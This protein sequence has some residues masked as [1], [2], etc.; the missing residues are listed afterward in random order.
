MTP[1]A[2]AAYR[3]ESGRGRS[4]DKLDEISKALREEAL[5]EMAESFFG[6]RKEVE[7]EKD[8]FLV[9]AGRVRDKGRLALDRAALL[10]ALLLDGAAAPA[11]YAVLGVEPG[12]LL[13]L[14]DPQRARLFL[15]RPIALTRRSRYASYVLDAYSVLHDACDDYLHGSTFEDTE[16]PERKVQT[17]S[18][19]ELRAW[20]D[21]INAEVRRINERMPP[22]LVLECAH[23]LDVEAVAKEEVTGA[24]LD[25]FA[26]ELDRGLAMTPVD[27]AAL[28]LPDLPELPAAGSA[29]KRVRRFARDLYDQAGER[30]EAIL[31][32]LVRGE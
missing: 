24:T 9:R 13:S 23:G 32:R 2:G 14:V 30:L 16:H 26:G 5:S 18:Y 11:F 15:A 12:P 27:F 6:A 8:L 4:M 10:H 25:G 3:M 1:E 29:A 28:S 21:Q 31:A 20:C 19:L 22:S 17:M 7:T